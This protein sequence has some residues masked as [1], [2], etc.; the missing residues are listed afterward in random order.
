MKKVF[1]VIFV[2]AFVTPLF[3]GCNN[4]GSVRLWDAQNDIRLRNKKEGDYHECFA[5]PIMTKL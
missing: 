4:S 2:L 1:A 5:L 3:Q